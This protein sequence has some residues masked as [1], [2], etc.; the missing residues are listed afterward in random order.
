MG[1]LNKLKKYVPAGFKIM[2]GDVQGG[3]KDAVSTTVEMMQKKP[4]EMSAQKAS[5]DQVKVV[6]AAVDDHQEDIQELKR[7]IKELQDRGK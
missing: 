2:T 4:V 1:W 7:L 6:A 3:I 5:I